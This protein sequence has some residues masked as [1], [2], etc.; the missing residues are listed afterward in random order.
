[1]V[2]FLTSNPIQHRF[3]NFTRNIPILLLF[4]LWKGRWRWRWFVLERFKSRQLAPICQ[5]SEPIRC[6][7]KSHTIAIAKRY[8]KLYK[9][10]H[11]KTF[12]SLFV[13][14]IRVE[15]CE[16]SDH[17]LARFAQFPHLD[18]VDNEILYAYYSFEVIVRVYT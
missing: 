8:S 3:C 7:S 12:I 4:L 16:Y 5:I 17:S 11:R 9:F 15:R 1:M 14:I 2:L 18:A 13:I 6:S 10:F